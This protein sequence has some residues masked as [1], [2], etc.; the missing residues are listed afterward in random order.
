MTRDAPSRAGFSL[1]EVLV[2]MFVFALVSVAVAASL[3]G[4]VRAREQLA[5]EARWLEDLQTMR[6]LISSDMQ[7]VV[8]RPARSQTGIWE[9]DMF[10]GGRTGLLR[11]TR[12]GRPNP[13]GMEARSELQRVRYVF[14][15]GKLLRETLGNENPGPQTR[16]ITRT[17]LAGIQAAKLDFHANGKSVDRWNVSALGG[18][19]ELPEYVTLTLQLKDGRELVQQ[20][21]VGT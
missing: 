5:Q 18:P 1:V 20:F 16:I 2:A 17:M 14:E 10:S 8:L 15:D 13:G 9:Q 3:Q 7:Y 4:A 12:G 6:A 21:E 11:F 19:Q